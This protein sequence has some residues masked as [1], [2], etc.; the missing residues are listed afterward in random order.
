MQQNQRYC[1]FY[2]THPFYLVVKFTQSRPKKKLMHLFVLVCFV[3]TL[4]FYKLTKSCKH[5]D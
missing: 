4:A 2:P 1:L 5:E 3:F